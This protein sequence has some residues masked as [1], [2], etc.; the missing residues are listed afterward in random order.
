MPVSDQDCDARDAEALELALEPVRLAA[1][2]DYNRFRSLLGRPNDV[3]IRPD[4]A[5]LV[6]FDGEAHDGRV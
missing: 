3:A 5:E 2:I 6:A 4:R 1:R